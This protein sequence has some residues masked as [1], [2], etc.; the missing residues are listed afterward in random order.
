MCLSWI[1]SLKNDKNDMIVNVQRKTVQ[2]WCCQIELKKKPLTYIKH[3][4]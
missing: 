2:N 3:F 1:K 4:K